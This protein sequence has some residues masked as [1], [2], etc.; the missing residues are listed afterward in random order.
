MAE[1]LV[2]LKIW[3]FINLFAMQRT[4]CHKSQQIFSISLNELLEIE[5]E[6]E[7]AIEMMMIRRKIEI[8]RV[9]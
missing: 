1:G 6:R 4:V 7:F 5:R 8:R 3:K 9:M 2:A